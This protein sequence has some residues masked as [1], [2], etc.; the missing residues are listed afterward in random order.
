M[1]TAQIIFTTLLLALSIQI[2]SQSNTELDG[3]HYLIKAKRT[4]GIL[5]RWPDD[6]LK[7]DNG[8]MVS[9]YMEKRE[10]FHAS[11]YLTSHS[12]N[13][14]LKANEFNYTAYNKYGSFLQIQ[15]T[16]HENTIQGIIYW[17]S[18]AGAHYYNFMGSLIS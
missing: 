2:F 10:G 5:G 4:N 6:T 18:D 15:G 16:Y 8:M 13:T 12:K 1:R 3:K 14:T 17:K 7:F 11:S 9:S